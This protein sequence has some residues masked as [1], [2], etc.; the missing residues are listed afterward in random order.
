MLSPDLFIANLFR[1]PFFFFSWALVVTFS[2]CLH[3]YLHALTA[4]RFGDDTAARN[5]HLTLNPLV[6]MGRSSLILLLLVGIAWGA[7]PVDPRRLRSRAAGAAV[8]LA[9]P[10]ANLVLC[11][12]FSLLAAIG[13]TLARAAAGPALFFFRL[14]ATANAVLFLFNMLPVPMFDGWPIFS[15]LLPRDRP[16]LARRAEMISSVVL[17]LFFLTPLGGMLWRLGDALAT[18]MLKGWLVVAARWV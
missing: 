17:L 10:L 15:L 18:A 9:G 4:L 5:G 1:D 16:L 11:V 12:M 3:E 8:A 13:L 2:V 14:G 7:V 6:Q